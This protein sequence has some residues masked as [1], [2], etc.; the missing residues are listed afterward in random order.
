MY[1]AGVAAVNSEVV[2]L[3]LELFAL[4]NSTYVVHMCTLFILCTQCSQHSKTSTYAL[5]VQQC[6]DPHSFLQHSLVGS[7]YEMF[8]KK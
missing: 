8:V 1:R 6:W 7:I 3:S 5:D 4:F 2:G